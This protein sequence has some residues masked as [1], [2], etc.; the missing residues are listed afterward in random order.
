MAHGRPP[1]DKAKRARDERRAVLHKGLLACYEIIDMVRKELAELD[2]QER[3][4][5]VR[6]SQEAK[7]QM[8]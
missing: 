7:G 3:T 1:I 2:A 5:P 6:P 8:K 4:A